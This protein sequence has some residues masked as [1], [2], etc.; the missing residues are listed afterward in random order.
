[1]PLAEVV[2]AAVVVPRSV[3]EPGQRLQHCAKG[4]DK[5]R[6]RSTAMVYREVD[7]SESAGLQALPHQDAAN[8]A[9]SSTTE[10]LSKARLDVG[11]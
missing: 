10:F 3:K 9:T 6:D 11:R 2:E 8:L 7:Y 1:M 4:P 5:C